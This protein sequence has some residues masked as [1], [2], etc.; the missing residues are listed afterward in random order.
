MVE[1]QNKKLTDKAFFRLVT[2]SLLCIL[3]SIT[4][5]CSATVAWYST[6]AASAGNTLE[7]GVF[8]LDVSVMNAGGEKLT[9]TK[10][11]SGKSTCT[12]AEGGDYTV[13]LSVSSDATVA[14]GFCLIKMGENVY[15]T[16]LVERDAPTSFTMTVA[17]SEATVTAVFT[18]NWGIPAM[19]DVVSGVL[20][21]GL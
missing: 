8:A 7:S 12:F 2:V 3:I 21:R 17:D 20:Q 13:T 10:T 4:C 18:P 15:A 1:K 6:N 14:S 19:P 9:V 16:D 5:L 11:E